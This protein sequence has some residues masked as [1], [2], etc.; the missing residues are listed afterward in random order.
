MIVYCYHLWAGA[1]KIHQLLVRI[2]KKRTEILIDSLLANE[3][4]QLPVI[5][6]VAS[7][8]LFCR[9]YFGKCRSALRDF[10]K[11]KILSRNCLR[12]NSF[13]CYH[14]N[15]ERTRTQDFS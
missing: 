9:V 5:R 13:T 3:L 14:F 4:L 8:S 6:N 11:P 15:I 10:K 12:A 2:V 1:P 7:L